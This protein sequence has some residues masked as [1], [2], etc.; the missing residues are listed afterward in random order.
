MDSQQIYKSILNSAIQKAFKKNLPQI[1]EDTIQ[2][3]E[4][5]DWKVKER[6]KRSKKSSPS[7]TITQRP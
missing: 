4:L 1:L 2:Y 7:K 6:R 3:L 5:H